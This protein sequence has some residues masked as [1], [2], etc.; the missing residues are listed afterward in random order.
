MIELVSALKSARSLRNFIED[1]GLEQAVGSIDVSAAVDAIRKM[2]TAKDPRAQIW[3]AVNHLEGAEQ[4]YRKAAN[5]W[6][7]RYFNSYESTFMFGKVRYVLCLQGACYRY[8]GEDALC[9]AA[10]YRAFSDMNPS[11]LVGDPDGILATARNTP[12]IFLTLAKATVN[13]RRL[14][15]LEPFTAVDALLFQNELYSME[16]GAQEFG[17]PGND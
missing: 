13:F 12:A 9:R 11:E 3:S 1:G 16:I 7:L 17:L 2:H 5:R 6:Q 14:D 4:A 15:Q 8:L 10:L